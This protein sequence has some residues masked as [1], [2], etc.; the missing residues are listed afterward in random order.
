MVTATRFATP[1]TVHRTELLTIA[2]RHLQ[3]GPP[4]RMA[5]PAPIDARPAAVLTAGHG[6][7]VA[8]PAR[9]GRTPEG[10]AGDLV[11]QRVVVDLTAEIAAH[12]R[13]P[14]PEQGHR[15]GPHLEGEPVGEP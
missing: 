15:L 8:G 1:A 9:L 4:D 13:L 5:L 7:L 2:S 3:H 6:H 11:E 14:I 10:A 12:R